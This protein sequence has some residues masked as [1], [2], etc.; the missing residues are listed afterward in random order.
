MYEAAK[1]CV[2]RIVHIQ[3]IATQRLE[4]SGHPRLLFSCVQFVFGK[5]LILQRGKGIVVACDEP[6]RLAIRD[7][8]RKHWLFSPKMRIE[9]I[10]VRL[11]LRL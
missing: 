7:F 9:R 6:S 1:T 10:R 2:V 5:P 3:H 8:H 11:E 4:K